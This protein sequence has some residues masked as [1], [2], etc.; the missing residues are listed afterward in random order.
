ME[1]TLRDSIELHLEYD[2]KTL[3]G[4]MVSGQLEARLKRRFKPAIELLQ[5]NLRRAIE[6]GPGLLAGLGLNG[7]GEFFS[8]PHIVRE[9][10]ACPHPAD[11]Y[12]AAIR[13]YRPD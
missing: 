9:E 8:G 3:F 13:I 7:S 5:L 4:T 12:P 1:L 2:D 11:A 6:Q 10:L